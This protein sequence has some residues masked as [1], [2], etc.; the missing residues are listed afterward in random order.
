MSLENFKQDAKCVINNL[1]FLACLLKKNC[2]RLLIHFIKKFKFKI[3]ENQHSTCLTYTAYLWLSIS[4]IFF[5]L[6]L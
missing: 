3:L 5:S 6:I 2:T 1:C 4:N